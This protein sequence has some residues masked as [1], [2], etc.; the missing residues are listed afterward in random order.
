MSMSERGMQ[1]NGIWLCTNCHQLVDRIDPDAFTVQGLLAMKQTAIERVPKRRGQSAQVVVNEFARPS[2]YRASVGSLRGA[3]HFLEQHAQLR[4]LLGEA[5]WYGHRVITRD[6]EQQ[7]AILANVWRTLGPKPADLADERNFC[8]DRDL[9]SLMQ[10]VEEAVNALVKPPE[11][12]Y[13]DRA[14]E[15][16]RVQ[17][18][19]YLDAT[20]LLASA[21]DAGRLP[22]KGEPTPYAP[23]QR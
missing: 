15:P 23:F 11:D 3:A 8:D 18:A 10:A 14:I 21:I 22:P 6:V 4:R 12:I 20:V 13:R 19:Q 7:I 5:T 1:H 16:L 17:I 2:A 9:L